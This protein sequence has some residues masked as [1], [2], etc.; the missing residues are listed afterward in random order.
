VEVIV[1]ANFK[2]AGIFEPP[3]RIS[4]ERKKPTLK[5][6]LQ[7]LDSL[8][9]SVHILRED[10]LSDDVEELSLNG[11]RAFCPAGASGSPIERQRPCKDRTLYGTP[12]GRVKKEGK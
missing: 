8:W 1:D 5:E 12:R 3:C 6:L 4:F 11:M 7:T 9:S 2:L 10:E